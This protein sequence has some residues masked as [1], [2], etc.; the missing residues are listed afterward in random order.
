MKPVFGDL[1]SGACVAVLAAAAV[2][3]SYALAAEPVITFNVPAGPMQASLVALARQGDIKIL[4]ESDVVAGL[5]APPLQ[6]RFTAREATE[7]LLAGSGISVEQVRPGVLVLRAPGSRVGEATNSPVDALVLAQASAGASDDD[8]TVAEVVVGTHIRGVADTASPAVVLGRDDMDR[9]GYSSV[10]DALTSLT[11]AF[12]GTASEDS[13]SSGADPTGSNV[14][15]GTGVDLR[16]LG[17]DATLV[18]FNGRRMAGAGYYGDFTDV[19]SIPYA[20]VGRVDVLLDGASALY[21]ADAVGGV[22]DIRLRTDLDG[23]ETRATGATDTRGGYSRYLF[24]QAVGKTWDSG[25]F[26]AAYEYTRNTRLRGV[27]RRYTG[28]ADLRPLGGSDWRRITFTAPA[29]ILRLDASGSFVPTYA[30]PSGQDGTGL[31]PADFTLGTANLENQR[32]TIDVLP[33]SAR[34]SAVMSAAQEVGRFEFSGDLRFAHRDTANSNL[35]PTATVI[36]TTANPHFV[37]PTGQPSERLGYSFSREIGG[38]SNPVMSESLGVSLNADAR[39]SADWKA[40]LFGTYAQELTISH[41]SHQLNVTRLNE[42]LGTAPDSP[43]TAFS[44]A[45]DGYFNPFIGQGS[46]P[47][48]VLDFILSG[49]DVSKFRSEIR[50]ANLAFDGPLFDLPG[51]TVRL[52]FGGQLRREELRTGGSSFFFGYS[53]LAKA[54]R[55]YSRDVKSAYAELNVPIVGSGN[56]MPLV[57]HLEL[58]LAGRVE[59]YEDVGSTANPKVGVIWEPG[60]G[61]KLKAS[62]GTSFRAPSLPE[63]A[64]PFTISPLELT[65]GTG[66][67]PTLFFQGGNPDLK[68]ETAKS[69]TG[70]VTYTPPALPDLTLSLSAYKTTFTN[71]I[72]SPVISDIGNALSSPDLA[73]FRVFVS[74]ATN[75]ADRATVQA[76]MDSPNALFADSYDV[77]DYRAIVEARNVN[78]GSLQVEGLDAAAA[79]QT[80]LLGDPLALNASMSWLTH[81]RRRTTPTSVETELAGHAGFPAD[82]RA[83][84]SASWTHGDYGVTTTVNH[85]GNATTDTGR[86]VKPWTTLDLQLRW[87][88]KSMLDVDGVT[89]SLNVQNAFDS[90][91]PFYD[92]PLAI[93]YDP[94]NADPLGRMV[95]LQLTKAW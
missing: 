9:A 81:Y 36:V 2:A 52:A 60:G 31:T 17:A 71:R 5:K 58:S 64:A 21:G 56:T 38:V 83:R 14:A 76:L 82:L 35:P 44:A 41:G 12:G 1:L 29:N 37:S 4:F 19:S 34:H 85:V 27:D 55:R 88:P 30:V 24:S 62:Y 11:Q 42:A 18:L 26:L 39:L 23:G 63:L 84:V 92:N 78:T 57:K 8:N 74:P 72:S 40:R 69:W 91:P 32:A 67:V 89:W 73:P 7:R 59:S 33:R 86:R 43:L 28:Y 22:V 77:T 87:Q 54:N 10:G 80:T 94:A 48:N 93:G 90:A 15:R 68:P 6:G 46:N 47:A 16:G 50:T 51:G 25:R 61:F 66:D 70:G 95:T 49:F 79:Y 20:A 53:P 45:R 65:Y 13:V 3:P 75:A